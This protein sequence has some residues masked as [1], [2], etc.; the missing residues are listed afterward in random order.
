MHGLPITRESPVL[1][2]K[3]K[4]FECFPGGQQ[5]EVLRI[6]LREVEKYFIALVL[7]VLIWPRKVSFSLSAIWLDLSWGDFIQCHQKCDPEWTFNFT[8]SPSGSHPGL[9]LL[10]CW[11]P[12][13]KRWLH[14]GS[15]PTVQHQIERFVLHPFPSWSSDQ[16]GEDK[17]F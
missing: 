7:F 3:R 17:I 15:R 5:G 11:L 1:L 6:K 9:P 13:S 16:H 12:L 4:Y 10:Y 2:K 14:Y 8:D